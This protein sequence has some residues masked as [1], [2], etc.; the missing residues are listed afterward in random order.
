MKDMRRNILIVL[1][2]RYIDIDNEKRLKNIPIMEKRLA[3][4]NEE[5]RKLK[6]KVSKAARDYNTIEDN[7]KAP[8][9]YPEDF[10][11]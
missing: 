2:C 9:E 5:Y 4:Y 11:W 10:E 8:L 1:N 7:I 3:E 6:I